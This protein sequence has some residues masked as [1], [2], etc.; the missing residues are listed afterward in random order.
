MVI[1]RPR[2][3]DLRQRS[4]VPYEYKAGWVQE[5]LDVEGDRNPDGP[6]R[7]PNPHL[8]VR[9]PFAILP[10]LTRLPKNIQNTG[11][12]YVVVKDDQKWK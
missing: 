9:S 10:D 5:T 6:S 11:K 1:I 7:D 12:F 4:P 2:W 8:S 3:L